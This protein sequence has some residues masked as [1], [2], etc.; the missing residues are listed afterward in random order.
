MLPGP[1]I[2]RKCKACQGLFK[3]RTL[4]SGN[5]FGARFW[6]DGAIDA[7]MLPNSSLI[8]KC[9]HCEAVDFLG[10]FEEVDWFYT[11]FVTPFGDTS[12]DA[13]REANAQKE[14]YYQNTPYALESDPDEWRDYTRRAD[15]PAD[16]EMIGRLLLWRFGND[17]R[18]HTDLYVPMSVDEHANLSRLAELFAS[19]DTDGALLLAEIYRELGRF[20]DAI[21]LLE[22]TEWPKSKRQAAEIIKALAKADDPQVCEIQERR[23]WE[24]HIEY[25]RALRRAGQ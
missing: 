16:S 25:R 14:L 21:A 1:T 18:R 11:Y 19:S 12:R 15:L 22:K 7:P 2:I 17:S 10:G 4:A 20:S 3:Q 23:N 24:F 8:V 5:T 13:E 6:T 9:P